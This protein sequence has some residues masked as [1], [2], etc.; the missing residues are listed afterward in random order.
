MPV[1]WEHIVLG[2][3]KKTKPTYSGAETAS[4]SSSIE[5]ESETH[6]G[7]ESTEDEKKSG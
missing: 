2:Q 7:E 6:T 4:S 5:P 1:G 3:K